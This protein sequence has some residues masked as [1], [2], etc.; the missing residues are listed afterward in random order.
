M[1]EVDQ[2]NISPEGEKQQE[3]QYDIPDLLWL[4]FAG[5]SSLNVGVVLG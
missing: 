5:R 2:T 3:I 1:G 4:I